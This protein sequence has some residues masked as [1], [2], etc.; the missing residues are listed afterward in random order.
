V[1]LVFV[2]CVP[3]V[4]ALVSL[5]G[6]RWYPVLD[7]AGTE[8]RLRDIS[9]GHPPLIGLFGRIGTLTRGGSH[10]GPLSFYA[11]WP[12][13]RLFGGSAFGLQA[14]MVVLDVVAIALCIWMAWRRGGL[15]VATGLA[16]ALAVL[17]RAYGAYLLTLAWN[18]YIP[19]LWWIVFLLAAWSVLDDDFAMAPI[20]LV[21]AAMCIQTH[22]SYLGLVGGTTA[23]V[24]AVAIYR[25]V[26]GRRPDARR[27]AVWWL[28]G[29]AA[30]FAVLWIPPIVDQINH[31]PGNLSVIYDYFRSPPQPPIGLAHG[32]SV[33][34]SQL[35]PVN[36][37]TRTIGHDGLPLT[38]SGSRVPGALLLVA[39][40]ASVGV[41]ARRREHLLLQ[42][43]IVL[44]A[45]TVFGVI[46]AAR[47]FGPVFDYLLLW[48]WGVAALMLLAVGWSVVVLARAATAPRAV[49]A[50]VGALVVVVLVASA[51]LTSSA[52]R[53]RVQVPQ[54]NASLAALAAP[55]ARTL[56]AMRA[57]GQRGPY[58]VTWSP[59]VQGI[60]A[61]GYGL[62]DALDRDG[63]DVRSDAGLGQ[64]QPDD[65]ARHVT[66]PAAAP[67][68]VHLATGRAQIQRWQ[69]DKRFREIAGYDG[70]TGAQA[71]E[72]EQLRTQLVDELR[73]AHLRRLAPLVDTDLLGIFFADGAP[74][75]ARNLIARMFLLGVPAAVFVGPPRTA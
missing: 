9:A 57:D 38:V 74:A 49:Q 15:P 28:V 51:V 55:T 4:V 75:R 32:F 68:E 36:L 25:L 46:S 27:S 16:A 7:M 21:A 31:S 40:V 39:F 48:A 10:P 6:T 65:T 26:T 35:D 3:L 67:V 72:Y 52:S 13:W 18:P 53:A 50:L 34:L 8:M 23:C 63:L 19:V 44:G 47:I 60:G 22:I 12:V 1:G 41:A 33:F 11:L 14:S 29:G 5:H 66:K 73:R 58:L 56:R 64:Y 61:Q 37:V 43:D 42:L 59:D 17:M 62:V 30:L 2:L 45:A 70:R 71:H 24:G 20:G 69:A 54:L